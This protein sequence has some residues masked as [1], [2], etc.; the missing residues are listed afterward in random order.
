MCA[1][2]AYHAPCLRPKTL[3][4]NAY[5]DL[6]A[7][8]A[9]QCGSFRISLVSSVVSAGFFLLLRTNCRE[10]RNGGS[11]QKSQFDHPTRL[12]GFGTERT[13]G[14]ARCNVS[15]LDE[16]NISSSKELLVLICRS[17]SDRPSCA[18]RTI[19]QVRCIGTSR[20]AAADVFPAASQREALLQHAAGQNRATPGGCSLRNAC[21]KVRR[22]IG[23][24]HIRLDDPTVL[25]I[26]VDQI[27]EHAVVLDWGSQASPIRRAQRAA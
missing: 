23:V 8:S 21:L 9:G 16:R 10:L 3:C 19:Q 15:G 14:V 18:A 24:L 13:E 25:R 4:A 22:Y 5:A 12:A 2:P 26:G 7:S 27:V 20:A 6:A 1:S 11:E 17:Q